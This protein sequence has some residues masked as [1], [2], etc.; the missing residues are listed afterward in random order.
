M[1]QALVDAPGQFVDGLRLIA[2]GF[3]VGYEGECFHGGLGGT[4][5]NAGIG[6]R[7]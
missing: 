4:D 6:G 2:G 3:K 1:G 7:V 5:G